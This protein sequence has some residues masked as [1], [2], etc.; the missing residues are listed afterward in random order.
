MAS[1]CCATIIGTKCRTRENVDLVT[2]LIERITADGVISKTGD[3]YPA[4]VLVLATGFDAQRMLAPMHIE[5]RNGQTIR[6]LWGDDN[7][8]AYLGITVPAFPNLFMI[9]GPGTK[10]RTWRKCIYHFERCVRYIMQCL[11]LLETGA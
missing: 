10:P 1:G 11:E 8:R 9:Y 4:D 7:P 2:D 6:A 3:F 5:G